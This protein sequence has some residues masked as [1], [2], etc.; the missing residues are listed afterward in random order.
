MQLCR[1][2]GNYLQHSRVVYTCANHRDNLFCLDHTRDS[3]GTHPPFS[4]QTEKLYLQIKMKFTYTLLGYK[5]GQGTQSWTAK[6]V[7]EWQYL[8]RKG[9][10]RRRLK[11]MGGQQQKVHSHLKQ[12]KIC[13]QDSYIVH[14]KPDRPW[15]I[16]FRHPRCS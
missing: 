16:P 11:I 2:R 4:F 9:G 5:N 7:T 6:Y 13:K 12:I 15:C 3:E 8:K 10:L 1:V 14:T